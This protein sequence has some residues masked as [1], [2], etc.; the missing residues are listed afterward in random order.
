MRPPRAGAHCGISLD[1]VWYHQYESKTKL[2]I[3]GG[4]IYRLCLII[5]TKHLINVVVLIKKFGSHQCCRV[6]NINLY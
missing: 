1:Y 6:N 2:E 5:Y 3:R 4:W